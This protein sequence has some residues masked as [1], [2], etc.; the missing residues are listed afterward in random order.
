MIPE[1]YVLLVTSW[2]EAG[3]APIRGGKMA[4]TLRQEG[5]FPAQN[6]PE[7]TSLRLLKFLEF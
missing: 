1:F 6:K 3:Q 7:V 5:A 4:D 2:V